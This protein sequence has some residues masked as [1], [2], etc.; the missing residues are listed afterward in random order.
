MLFDENVVYT[1]PM[2][3]DCVLIHHSSISYGVI[4]NLNNYLLLH[5]N[6]Y[7]LHTKPNKGPMINF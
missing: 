3:N 1:K 6:F 4:Q 2:L 5:Y 7:I